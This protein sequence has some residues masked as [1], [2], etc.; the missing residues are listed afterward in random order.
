MTSNI[1]IGNLTVIKIQDKNNMNIK[2][3]SEAK[4]NLL[5]DLDVKYQLYCTYKNNELESSTVMVYNNGKV[6]SISKTTKI[7]NYYIASNNKRISKFYN[8][9]N[10]SGAL[11]YFKEPKNISYIFSESNNIE[12]PIRNIG[13]EKYQIT[14]PKNGKQNEYYYKK[15]ILQRA[16]IHDTFITVKLILKQ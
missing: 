5:I 9:I 13:I 7:G 10:Y 11:L 1:E 16:I 4:V 2:I 8:K 12:K 14:N 15:G 6:H 3:E